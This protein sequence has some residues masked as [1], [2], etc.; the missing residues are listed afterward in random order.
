MTDSDQ[1][2]PQAHTFILASGSPYRARA[3]RE[4]GYDFQVEVPGTDED[5]ERAAAPDVSPKELAALLGLA[6]CRAVAA[7][8]AKQ[9]V[10]AGDQVGVCNETILTKPGNRQRAIEQLLSCSS[11][12]ALF[13]SS[14]VVWDPV[15]ES[16]L[17]TV[18][19]TELKFRTLSEHEVETYVD[20]D[21]PLDCAGAFKIESRGVLLF[22][23]VAAND[24]TALVGLPMLWV[25][26]TL[27][28]LGVCP[29]NSQHH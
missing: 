13:H 1:N 23:K 19:D 5:A 16:F 25:Q 27:R 2:P 26:Q 29:L 3:L 12:T 10:V 28:T 18:V 8:H 14:A 17:Q 7:R 24:P 15:A 21:Q 22:E 6:K 4:L 20:L 11:S 9:I